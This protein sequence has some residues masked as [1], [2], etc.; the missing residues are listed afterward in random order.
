MI[1]HLAFIGMALAML[2][3]VGC[4]P[5]V[6]TTGTVAN[7]PPGPPA[8]P[9]PP[10]PQPLDAT[11]ESS[12]SGVPAETEPGNDVGS[13]AGSD[14]AIPGA[15]N[16]PL[17]A[18]ATS[19]PAATQQVS[20]P[21]QAAPSEP[22]SKSPTIRLSAGVALPQ[23]LPEGTQIGVSVDYVLGGT[24]QSSCQ[25]VLVIESSAGEIGMPV[26]LEPRGTLQGF[27]PPTVRP[28]HKPFHARIDEIPPCGK[29]VRI[30]NS[31]VLATSY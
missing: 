27:L 21:H 30:S 5:P 2:L 26:Q 3:L 25:Y 29:A 19:E 16:S 24:S 6:A 15:A 28:E 22:T 31:A 13:P 23:L 1:R 11:I 14:A 10:A 17:P 4:E 7:V 9:V 18:A 12:P 20:A 8:P